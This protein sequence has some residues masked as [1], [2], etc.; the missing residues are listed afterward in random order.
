MDCQLAPGPAWTEERELDPDR[1]QRLIAMAAARMEALSLKEV[2]L[3]RK[4]VW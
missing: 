3:R 4:V 2:P 1:R